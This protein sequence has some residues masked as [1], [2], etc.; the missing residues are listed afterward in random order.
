MS[1]PIV[2]LNTALEGCYRIG[3]QLGAGG[4]ATVYLAAGIDMWDVA[5]DGQRFVMLQVGAA[6][7]R[8]DGVRINL[9]QNFFTELLERVPVD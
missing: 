3:R 8:G 4:M 9:V 5:P 2:R 6:E 7:P 1:D